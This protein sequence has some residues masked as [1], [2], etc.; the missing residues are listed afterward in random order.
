LVSG[1]DSRSA[2]A[3]TLGG[4]GGSSGNDCSTAIRPA[5]AFVSTETG[6]MPV[7]SKMGSTV[8]SFG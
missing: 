3:V 4:G 5:Y 8:A 1:P 7:A 6:T 2:S